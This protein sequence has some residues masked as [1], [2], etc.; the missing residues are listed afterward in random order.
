[1]NWIN[2]ALTWPS[3][4][5]T[6]QTSSESVT[7]QLATEMN[8]AVGRLTLLTGDA[9]FQRHPL[10]VD[11]E[12]LLGLRDDLESLLTQGQLLTATP[13]QFQVGEQ[14]NSG[15]Y[16]NPQKALEVLCTKLR[17]HI[18][19]NR[20]AGQ[21]YCVAIMVSESQLSRF[22]STLTDLTKI[23]PLPEW[24]QV[25]RQSTALSTNSVDKY[26]QPTDIVQPRFKPMAQL[27]AN[28][29]RD[30]LYHQ[31][32][33][34]AT[35]ESLAND[36]TNVIDKLQKLA[37]KRTAKL[38]AVK[39]AINTL[40]NINGNVWFIKLTGNCESIATQLKQMSLPNNN[41]HTIMSLMLSPQPLTF[42][43]ELLCSA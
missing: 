9:N 5:Q 29:L 23:L 10:S 34:L 35:L 26:H 7:N 21:L 24:C 31:G 19:K 25:A 12:K 22:A 40:K 13:Y 6:L 15:S 42:F 3:S 8:N 16:L 1:M 38:D 2:T 4:A 28:P 30:M 18:D 32:S 17:D 39:T 14:Q 27:N 41:Q 36:K 43:E 11:A 20:P 33:Q 37:N